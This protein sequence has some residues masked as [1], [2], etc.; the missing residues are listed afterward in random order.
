MD[1]SF[2]Q[3]QVTTRAAVPADVPAI[4]GGVI[5]LLREIGGKPAAAELLEAEA[6]ELIGDPKAGVVLVAEDEERIVGVLG[7]SWQRAIRVPGRYG[8]IQEL[9]VAPSHRDRRVG[10]QLLDELVE[11][12]RERSIARLEVGL[13]GERF[14]GLVAT[15]AFYRKNAF[16]PVGLRMR[17]LL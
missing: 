12:S 16:E 2:V 6:R 7:V 8:L 9:W 14:A 4:V 10:G 1:A 17:R 5:K 13:P 3:T 15:E 11:V